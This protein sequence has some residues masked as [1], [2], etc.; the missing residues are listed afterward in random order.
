[1]DGIM[2][3]GGVSESVWFWGEGGWYGRGGG[4]GYNGRGM[5]E[6]EKNGV[7]DG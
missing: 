4:W 3:G 7:S 5:F 1:M 2:M 6:K